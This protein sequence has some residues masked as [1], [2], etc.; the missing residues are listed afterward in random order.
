M[1][2]DWFTVIAQIIN[3]LV[4]MWLLKKF[5]Y[6]PILN[7]IT[8]REKHISS[9]LANAITK[10]AEAQQEQNIFQ[11]KNEEF[12]DQKA[13]L[14]RNAVKEVEETR[15][16]LLDKA[17]TDVDTLTLNMR[18]SLEKEEANLKEEVIHRTKKTVF[19]IAT[20]VLQDLANVNLEQHMCALFLKNLQDLKIEDKYAL[21]DSLSNNL[22]VNSAFSLS[23]SQHEQI[24][25]VIEQI[26]GF[27]INLKFKIKP[28]LVSGLELL[29]NGHKIAWS[30]S[31]YLT[32]L[33]ASIAEST[34]QIPREMNESDHAK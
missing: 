13:E 10:E 9:Q 2:I 17:K 11:R 6:K 34:L 1:H 5:L 18:K 32:G 14:L 19:V 26:S 3:F 30:L 25:A 15:N 20:K 8:V 23:S 27:E 31:D 24:K 12:N 22:I 7:A 4:L 21:T 28:E 16:N 29:I 33:E